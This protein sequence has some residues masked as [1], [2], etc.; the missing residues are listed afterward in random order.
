MLSIL[1]R[2][3]GHRRS[4]GSRATVNKDGDPIPWYTYPAIEYLEQIDF[5]NKTV[6]EWGAGNSSLYWA[7]VAKGVVSVD[8]NPEWFQRL[9][10]SRPGNQTVHLV[11]GRQ[12]YVGFIAKANRKYDV[13]VI[14]GSFRYDCSLIAPKYL[15]SGGLIILDN[16]DWWPKSAGALRTADLLQVDMSGFGPINRVT[17]TTSLFFD[18]TFRMSSKGQRQPRHGIGASL[19]IL[20]DGCD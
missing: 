1:D 3:L 12:E 14:D 7:R 6:F 20:D 19:A 17:W 9:E 16:S 5:S 18:R 8:D 13:I 10:T 2:E 4:R 15:A 11:Q